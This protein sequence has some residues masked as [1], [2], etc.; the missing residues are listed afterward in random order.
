[1]SEVRIESAADHLD[2]V[3]EVARW[4][5][6]NGGWREDPKGSV[7][8][9]TQGLLGRT[10]R[11]RIPATYFALRGNDLVG[12]VT[13]VEHD[14]PDRRDLQD[15]GP[16]LAGVHVVRSARGAGIG[17]RLVRHAEE[18]ARSFGVSRLFLYTSLAA[19]F[20]QRL[21]WRTVRQDHF[22]GPITIMSKDLA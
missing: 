5:W 11:D 6:E 7:D 10:N 13:L 14:L 4:H 15:F 9:W 12:S 19:L 21:G 20:Y 2:R 18:R 22:V 3:P 1:M 8:S 16:W 17:S